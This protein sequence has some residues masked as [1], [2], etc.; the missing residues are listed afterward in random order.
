[1]DITDLTPFVFWTVTAVTAVIEYT[2][3]LVA[4]LMSAWIPAPP[5]ESDPAMIKIFDF[6]FKLSNFF[7][8]YINTFN[9]KSFIFTFSHNSYF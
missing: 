3:R 7:Q 9:K 6:I 5:D 1:M 2:P 8:N 4:V